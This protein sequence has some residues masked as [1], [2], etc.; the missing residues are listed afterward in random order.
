MSKKTISERLENWSK[1]A[2]FSGGHGTDCMTGVVCDGMRKAA[3]GNV[4]SGAHAKQ[5]IDS[6]DATRVE[7]AMRSL[8][9]LNQK[10]LKWSYINN[11]RPEVVCRKI[12]LQV[13]PANVFTQTFRAAELEIEQKLDM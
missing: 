7:L 10:I 4:W 13:R 5:E 2:R 8:S 6:V 11:A 1:W 9:E 12:G 3:L